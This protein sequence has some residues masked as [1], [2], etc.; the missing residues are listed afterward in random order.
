VL[1][2]HPA[3]ATSCLVIPM[4]LLELKGALCESVT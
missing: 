2:I 3:Y 1:A 4:L